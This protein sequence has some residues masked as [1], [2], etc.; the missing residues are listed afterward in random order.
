VVALP[1][2]GKAIAGTAGALTATW[3]GDLGRVECRTVRG[4]AHAFDMAGA[5]AGLLTRADAGRFIQEFDHVEVAAA[6]TRP[7][8]CCSPVKAWCSRPAATA[9]AAKP[10]S[11]STSKTMSPAAV[12]RSYRERADST[13]TATRCPTG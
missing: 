13:R 10:G 2:E 12:Y 11:S 1:P 3:N 8:R 6:W 5:L 4:V 9:A 7:A